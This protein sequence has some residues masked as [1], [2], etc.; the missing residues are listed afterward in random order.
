LADRLWDGQDGGQRLAI[1]GG[2]RALDAKRTRGRRVDTNGLEIGHNN[3]GKG[4]GDCRCKGANTGQPP[5][6]VRPLTRCRP[7]RS[8]PAKLI[9]TFT[10]FITA[11]THHARICAGRIASILSS[12]A[13][14]VEILV[15]CYSGPGC[16]F[17]IE[18]YRS[19]PRQ[20]S[21]S[22]WSRLAEPI[23]P[24]SPPHRRPCL[25]SIAAEIRRPK[26]GSENSATRT[27]APVETLR[28][29]EEEG[30]KKNQKPNPHFGAA[31]RSE[32]QCPHSPPQHLHR[33]PASAH[34]PLPSTATAI[35]GNPTLL[36]NPHASR[37]SAPPP[38][39]HHP[40]PHL[41]LHIAPLPLAP[42]GT[43]NP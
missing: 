41:V 23:R 27:T 34:H 12:I 21:D 5:P 4:L 30:K 24:T 1:G 15:F 43:Q 3:P 29:G 14:S 6:S 37:K 8:R 2:A 39:H 19:A 25:L 9:W 40:A 16:R 42:P 36:V 22:V 32:S 13:V 17:Y 26:P 20:L 11:D 31:H 28:I 33:R 38:E 7:P 10:S 18:H 35:R